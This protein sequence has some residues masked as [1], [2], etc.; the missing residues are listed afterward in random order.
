MNRD[1]KIIKQNSQVAVA[2][3]SLA[4]LK[5]LTMHGL[6]GNQGHKFPACSSAGDESIPDAVGSRA[7]LG[8]AGHGVSFQGN[9]GTALCFQTKL[10]RSRQE[11]IPS[12]LTTG[13]D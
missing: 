8:T 10:S 4:N 5:W 9:L 6:R 2:A 12:S 3:V 13:M 11:H 7:Q 1:V